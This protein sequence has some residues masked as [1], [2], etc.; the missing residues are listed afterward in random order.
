MD[1]THKTVAVKAI[2]LQRRQLHIQSVVIN[3]DNNQSIHLYIDTATLLYPELDPPQQKKGVD[4][5]LWEGSILE[6]DANN[7]LVSIRNPKLNE[8]TA[9]CFLQSVC[10]WIRQRFPIKNITLQDFQDI[11]KDVNKKGSCVL[12]LLLDQVMNNEPVVEIINN[13]LWYQNKVNIAQQLKQDSIAANIC[14]GKKELDDT[15]LMIETI[16][17]F[18]ENPYKYMA[19]GSRFKP[20]DTLAKLYGANPNTICYENVRYQLYQIQET[21]GHSCFAKNAL[22]H[23]TYVSMR[24]A[25]PTITLD[26]VKTV[27]ETE[28]P[29]L[30]TFVYLPKTL[31]IE[32][33]LAS[34]VCEFLDAN[35]D[36]TVSKDLLQ[37]TA[38]DLNAM[39]QEWQKQ[40]SILLNKKQKYA[41]E[42]ICSQS[43]LFI[44]TGYPGTGKSAIVSFVEYACKEQGRKLLMCAPTG[45]AANVLGPDAMTIHRALQCT[46]YEDGVMR[47]A[48]DKY[49]KLP[50]DIVVVDE[51]SMLDNDI[52]YK[53]LQAIDPQK[54]KLLLLGDKQQLPP[55]QYGDFLGQLIKS[56]VVPTIEL[57]HIYRQGKGSAICKLAKMVSENKVSR[58]ILEHNAGD[59]VWLNTENYNTKLDFVQKVYNENPDLVQVLA[60]SKKGM[61]GTVQMNGVIHNSIFHNKPDIV[62]A[63]DK[64]V[65]VKNTYTKLDDDTVDIEKS[66]FNGETGIVLKERSKKTLTVRFGLGKELD[67]DRKVVDFGYALSVHKSQGSQ[68]DIVCLVLSPSP[69]I[70]L[71][72]ELLYT[73]IT[74]TKTKLY[75]VGED[76]CILKSA[77]TPAPKRYSNIAFLI[78]QVYQLI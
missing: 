5:I 45:K 9:C 11:N 1:S 36:P 3:N 18:R 6:L 59:I 50:Y 58:E 25:H 29:S 60:P 14:L 8:A 61:A 70:M 44:L 64:V 41:L 10:T 2:T 72:R 74:R 63:G 76:Y 4:C 40:T 28:F 12:S 38:Q 68:Y 47:F 15:T 46:M 21:D 42:Q 31:Q 73:A 13:I 75:I 65:C 71:N 51:T 55:V 32:R 30:N 39:L 66:A 54:T 26:M 22:T 48:Y 33:F 49:R 20:F 69:E 53:L 57:T 17:Q 67:I 43:N 24:H 78:N 23:H 52:A 77:A 16:E 56:Q 7:D 27:V 37:S 62:C 34:K 19:K 35:N